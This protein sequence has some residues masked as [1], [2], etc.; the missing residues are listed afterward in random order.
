MTYDIA[1][2]KKLSNTRPSN[3]IVTNCTTANTQ[4]KFFNFYSFVSI[5]DSGSENI[6]SQVPLPFQVKLVEVNFLHFVY[7]SEV[8]ILVYRSA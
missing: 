4:I 1:A 3:F 7:A 5:S 8:L 2:C 6:D